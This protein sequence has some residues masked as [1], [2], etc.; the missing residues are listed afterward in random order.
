M[1]GALPI[2]CRPGKIAGIKFNE[3]Q[4]GGEMNIQSMRLIARFVHSAKPS[5]TSMKRCVAALLFAT[6][7]AS[8]AFSS[9]AEASLNKSGSTVYTLMGG[10]SFVAG[11]AG[12]LSDSPASAIAGR[13]RRQRETRVVRMSRCDIA[14][15]GA[16][17]CRDQDDAPITRARRIAPCG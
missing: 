12:G 6:T 2:N 11:P 14:I 15:C 10:N 8:G 13:V 7:M 17:G 16:A 3:I 4:L 5:P 1:G 9:R